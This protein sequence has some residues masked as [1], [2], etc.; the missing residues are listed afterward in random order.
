MKQDFNDDA[1]PSFDA[2]RRDAEMKSLT[3]FAIRNPAM[4]LYKS[5]ADSI[6]AFAEAFRTK[7]TSLQDYIDQEEKALKP[8]CS[9][10]FRLG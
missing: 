1:S 7:Y 8:L 4:A 9:K 5:F 6:D 10:G 3:T 2:L